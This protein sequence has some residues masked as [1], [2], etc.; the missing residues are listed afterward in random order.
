MISN[1]LNDTV[2]KGKKTNTEP[3]LFFNMVLYY[4]FSWKKKKK[5]LALPLDMISNHDKHDKRIKRQKYDKH[6]KHGKRIER[7]TNLHCH[8]NRWDQDRDCHEQKPLVWTLT[9]IS[10]DYGKPCLKYF[11]HLLFSSSII[12]IFSSYLILNIHILCVCFIFLYFQWI[13]FTRCWDV[14]L[15]ISF[16]RIANGM[17]Q[18][19]VCTHICPNEKRMS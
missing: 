7:H 11:S 2:L 13:Y 9:H 4:I 12:I 14:V 1:Y 5:T 6:D 18:C 15:T 10:N 3:A 17:F 16:P 8:W 19:T